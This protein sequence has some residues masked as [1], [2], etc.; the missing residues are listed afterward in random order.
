MKILIA[1]RNPGKL[2]EFAALLADLPVEWLTLD[3]AGITA[4]VEERGAT[5]E[6]NARLKAAGYA[7]ESGLW[8]LAEDSGLEVDALNGEPGV[9]SARYGGPGLDDT[10]RYRLLL[11]NLEDVP[12]EERTARYRSVIAVATPQGEIVTADGVREGL[13]AHEPRG[14]HGFGYDPIFWLPGYRM[15]MA[16]LAP[17]AKN[18]ISHRALSVKAIRPK[19][20]EMI[21]GSAS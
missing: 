14:S 1:T 13:I 15:T 19:L 10:D 11:R 6:E 9:F 4:E 5:F 7:R 18:E 12:T 8:T 2:R 16:E 17:E 21:R 3:D 20:E